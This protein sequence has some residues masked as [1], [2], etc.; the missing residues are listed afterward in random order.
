MVDKEEVETMMM[1][2]TQG[3][4]KEK[5]MT[6]IPREKGETMMMMVITETPH[7]G[8]DVI[9]MTMEVMMIMIAE[10]EGEKIKGGVIRKMKTESP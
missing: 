10:E 8:G 2:M 3:E 6:Q 9:L 7:E 5:T 1:E 4:D